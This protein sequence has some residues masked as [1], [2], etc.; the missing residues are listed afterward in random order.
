MSSQK[1]KESLVQ[2]LLLLGLGFPIYEIRVGLIIYQGS[3][4]HDVACL[5][6]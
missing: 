6:A 4:T 5:Q 1:R 2:G 3:Y